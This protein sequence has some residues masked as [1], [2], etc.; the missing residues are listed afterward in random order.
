MAKA[1]TQLSSFP[2][3]WLSE[4]KLKQ[5]LLLR[6]QSLFNPQ[7][8]EKTEQILQF[9]LLERPSHKRTRT[10]LQ[11]TDQISK[12]TIARASDD[13]LR[14]VLA[15]SVAE[16]YSKITAKYRNEAARKQF[17]KRLV[18]IT[19]AAHLTQ[20]ATTLH[21]TLSP[22]IPDE[23]LGSVN[24]AMK[25]HVTDRIDLGSEYTSKLSLARQEFKSF[26]R[27]L[28]NIIGLSWQ[29]SERYQKTLSLT[30]FFPPNIAEDED[31]WRWGSQ[32]F[33]KIGI[34]N[35]NPPM[36]FFDV[37][38]KGVLAREAAILLS[39][40]NLETM[41]N[42]PRVLC[43]Q[44]EYLASKL[45]ERKNDRELWSEAR[46][47]LRKQTRVFGHELID[48]FH[49]YEMMVGDSLYRE[50]WSRLNE[51]G[52]IRL[53]VSDYYTI[54]NT[55]ASRPTN[56]KFSRQEK[57]LLVLLSK[58]PDVKAGEAAGLLKVSVP[59]AMKAIRDLS[60]KAGL[61]FNV[62]VDMQRLGL[63]ENLIL[64][65]AAKQADVIRV[66]SR[67]PYCRQVFRTYGSFDL[68]TVLDI[69]VEHRAFT[70]EFMEAMV[71]TRVI[72]RYKILELQRDL[73]AVNFD[74][75]NVERA[76]WDVHWDTW[77][78][79]LRENLAKGSSSSLDYARQER[80][81]Q[82]DKLD[83]NILLNLQLDCRSPFSALGRS[84]NVS[85]AY[86]GKKVSKML[87]EMAFKYALWPLKIG[88]EDWGMIGLTCSKQVAGTLA[89]SLSLLPAW[90][91]GLVTGDFEGLFAIVWCPNGEVRQ[92]FK[93]I[94]DRL[95][96]AGLAQPESMNSVGEW[97]VARWLPVDPDEST[98]W[99]LFSDDGRWLF[100]ESRYLA[101]T[102]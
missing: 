75:Y 39:P 42:A 71:G 18:Q 22:E 32:W 23:A 8:P 35:I 85:G 72:T 24:A 3:T 79:G 102:K 25:R 52:E 28:E 66:L 31:T 29:E 36:L 13:Y 17:F 83:L 5:S 95:V 82:L 99:H 81:I 40:R 16:V 33:P 27:Q 76:S 34:L 7:N 67:F 6:Q 58:R 2:V 77:G 30:S 49:F 12:D 44:A 53:T 60:K 93:A 37:L 57:E 100:D 65:N 43:E 98:P 68:F 38:R 96:R 19:E 41:E 84:L 48:F 89:Q 87:R 88:A 61:R 4:A 51:F 9:L 70:R 97:V 45:F 54:F 11:S 15:K 101:L 94:D 86:I 10:P 74:N 91:G 46:H 1:S 21:Q 50:L 69:P 20:S 73:Q 56:P 80:N 47:G 55:L 78:I 92:F 62:I 26:F 14:C 64:I 90:R 59:T 63:I